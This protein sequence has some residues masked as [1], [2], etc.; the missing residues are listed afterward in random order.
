MKLKQQTLEKIF[1]YLVSQPYA[2]VAQLIQEIQADLQE[3]EKVEAEVE[4]VE[5][6]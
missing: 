3:E 2:Q 4:Q 6:D 5:E 1:Q